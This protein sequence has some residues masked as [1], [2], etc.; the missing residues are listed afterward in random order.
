MSKYNETVP[1]DVG[2]QL[3]SRAANG[4]AKFTIT[5]AASTADDLSKLT[6]KEL[7]SLTAIPNEVQAGVITNIKDDPTNPN[8][9]I[10]TELLF[11]NEKIEAG[12]NI[13]AV[14]IYAKEDGQDNEILYAVTLA[15]QAEYMP[16][17]ADQV[18]LQ[19]KLTVYVIV[20]RTENVTVSINITEAATKEY[21][22]E[23]IAKIDI[24]D[25]LSEQDLRDI[26][27]GGKA[28]PLMGYQ[29]QNQHLRNLYLG[30]KAVGRN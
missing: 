4:Q 6:D 9:A 28:A 13:N 15:Q 23:Q 7:Q 27:L 11:T 16:D 8:G 22:D 21:V 18:I 19:F 2:L 30:G 24:N 29:I 14:G 17:F 10:G 1:T 12:Y 3:A 25:K 26:F 20:G 5:R